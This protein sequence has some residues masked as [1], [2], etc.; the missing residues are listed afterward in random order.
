MMRGWLGGLGEGCAMA[1]KPSFPRVQWDNFKKNIKNFLFPHS[2]DNSDINLKNNKEE[3][4]DLV[5]QIL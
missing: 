2:N 1:L 3:V 5:L 4:I